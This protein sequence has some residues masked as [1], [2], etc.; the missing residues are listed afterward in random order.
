VHRLDEARTQIGRALECKAPFGYAAAPWTSWGLLADIEMQAANIDAAA[1]AKKKAVSSYLAYRHDGG[2]NQFGP[3]RIA[4]AVIESLRAGGVSATNSL[5]DKL[6]AELNGISET[7]TFI[8]ALQAIVD[9]SR[10][11]ALADAP[12]LHYTTAAEILLLIET[13]DKPKQSPEAGSSHE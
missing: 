8:R 12:D 5:L 9:G 10:N 13:L 7:A 11:R 3:G 2:E 4:V 1:E 6:A